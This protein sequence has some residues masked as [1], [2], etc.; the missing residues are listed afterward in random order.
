MNN[1]FNQE[2][3]IMTLTLDDDSQ[4]Q[5]YVIGIFPAGN[6][7]Y[8]ALDPIDNDGFDGALVYRYAESEEGEMILTNIEDDEEYEIVADAFDE[9]LDT[10]EFYEMSDMDEED[11]EEEE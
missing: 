10:L 1:Q 11:E 3:D 5:C 2:E 7:E 4:V 8:I 6:Y 9:L